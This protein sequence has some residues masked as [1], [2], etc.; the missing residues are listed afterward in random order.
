MQRRKVKKT[1]NVKKWKQGIN[2]VKEI[3][4]SYTRDM[5]GGIRL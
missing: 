1:E 3:N 4:V 2:N 5:R